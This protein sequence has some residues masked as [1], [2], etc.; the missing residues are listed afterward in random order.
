MLRVT[1]K[2]VRGHLVRFLL[3]AFA[4]TL[5]VAFVAGSYVLRDS[6]NNTLNSLLDSA[7]KGLDVSVRGKEPAKDAP[8]PGLPI[9]LA[10]R[11]AAVDGV[12]RSSP[13]VQ[14]QAL[15]VGKDGLVVRNGGAPGLGFAYR[16]ADPS[17]TLVAGRG[18]N[19]PGEIVVEQTTLTKSGL[20]VGDSTEALIGTEARTVQIT[21]EVTF[22]S[23][24]GATAVLVDEATA[25]RAFAPDDSVPSISL[26]ARPGISQEVLK[27]R[28]AAA[29]PATA[30][31]VTGNAIA[32]E[33]KSAVQTGLGFVTTFLLVF[34]GIT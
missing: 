11:L 27:Q 24:F 26:T 33:N 22:G 9:D 6:I 30:E 18:P 15:I 23:L 21:G 1:L 14:G 17:F 25:R 19:G 12:A 31:A 32:D 3:T 5:G 7:T 13:D 28:V 8:R 20:A 10:T 29:L 34:A 2:G 16:A 4:V